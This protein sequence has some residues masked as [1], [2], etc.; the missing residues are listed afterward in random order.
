MVERRPGIS[1]TYKGYV[2]CQSLD[3]GRE[4]LDITRAL[5][6][7]EISADVPVSLKRGCS[8]YP[9]VYPEYNNMG[10][11]GE[12]LMI[13]R[14]EWREKEKAA[15]EV[16][17]KKFQPIIQDS[18]D[19]PGFDQSDTLAMCA[20]LAYAAAIGDSSYLTITPLSVMR[21]MP[22]IHRSVCQAGK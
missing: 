16:V 14:E 2:F 20:W 15:E 7:E 13:Y 9:L 12:P 6:A 17:S 18:F 4:M 19:H 8:E 21:P 10:G 11:E 22:N 5:V 3:E 1:G